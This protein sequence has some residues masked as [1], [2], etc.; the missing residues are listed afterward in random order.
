LTKHFLAMGPENVQKNS[1]IPLEICGISPEFFQYE[2]WTSK[3][4]AV[5]QV[6]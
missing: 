6:G 5:L 2:Q 4:K 1:K 3:L